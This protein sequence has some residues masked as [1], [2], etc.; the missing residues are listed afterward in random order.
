V[1]AQAGADVGLAIRGTP[2]RGEM[3]VDIGIATPAGTHRDRKLALLRGSQGADRAAIA[4]AS[5][6]LAYLRG[7]KP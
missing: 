6:V 1:R 4:A 7:A 3:R 5:V 2:A